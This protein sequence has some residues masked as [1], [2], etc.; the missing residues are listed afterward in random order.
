MNTLPYKKAQMLL[1]WSGK[2][3]S[4]I[5]PSYDISKYGHG[6]KLIADEFLNQGFLRLSTPVE[7]IEKA[8]VSELKQ[9]LKSVGEKHTGNKL[10]LSQRIINN[11][12]DTLIVSTFNRS[13]YVLTD[14]GNQQISQNSVFFLADKFNC[15]LTEL[16]IKIA[17]ESLQELPDYKVLIEILNRKLQNDIE[18]NDWN[19]YNTHLRTLAQICIE[20]EE[21][22]NA[23]SYL[24]LKVYNELSGIKNPWYG[25]ALPRVNGIEYVQIETETIKKLDESINA[26]SWNLDNF[27][28][29]VLS[30]CLDIIP[31]Y[32]FHYY[33][34]DNVLSIVCEQLIGINYSSIACQL[35]HKKPI[36]DS[37][38]YIY[39]SNNDTYESCESCKEEDKI[40]EISFVKECITATSRSLLIFFDNNHIKY[41]VDTVNIYSNCF[42]IKLR[43]ESEYDIQLINKYQGTIATLLES[44][45]IWTKKYS[46]LI[47]SIFVVYPNS[48]YNKLKETDYFKSLEWYSLSIRNGD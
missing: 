30:N 18:N 45:M 38:E 9:F 26:L 22:E 8:S 34:V 36:A 29:Y 40:D 47:E 39:H 37:K 13:F 25:D 20:Y 42:E 7:N 28:E 11:Y 31:N 35:P 3:K 19:L 23:V 21:Y 44:S 41:D 6:L 12:S 15:G 32:V 46:T 16:E 1:Y 10:E 33:S 27:R 14:L 48:Y 5:V 4:H 17:A 2:L 43:F 24:W